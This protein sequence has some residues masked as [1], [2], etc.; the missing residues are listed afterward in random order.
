MAEKHLEDDDLSEF[1]LGLVLKDS[2]YQSTYE[3]KIERT[4]APW[5]RPGLDRLN[6]SKLLM[7]TLPMQSMSVALVYAAI[8]AMVSIFVWTGWFDSLAASRVSVFDHQQFW[9]IFTA[10]FQHADAKHLL[11]NLLP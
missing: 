7:R 1:S 10:Q 2:I 6:A 3:Y 4:L 11:N 9:R 8:I 5:V